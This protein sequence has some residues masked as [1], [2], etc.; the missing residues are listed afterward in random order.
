MTAP[1]PPEASAA[2]TGDQ[3]STRLGDEVV[4]LGLRDSV[5]YGLTD[6][7][8]RIWELLQTRRT[9]AEIVGVMVEEYDVTAEQAEA[10]LNRLLADLQA[11]GLV[12]VSEPDR[13]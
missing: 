13:S 12:A 10:D 11:R 8:A 1:F 3:L 5:Y 9:L 2:A 6:V 7:G 4:I